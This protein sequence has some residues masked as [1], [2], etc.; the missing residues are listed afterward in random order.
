MAIDKKRVINDVLSLAA[1]SVEDTLARTSGQLPLFHPNADIGETAGEM[2]RVESI[3]QKLGEHINRQLENPDT[4]QKALAETFVLSVVNNLII[5]S[6]YKSAIN[7]YL[8]F[9]ET[10]LDLKGIRNDERDACRQELMDIVDESF[11]I[12]TKSTAA[13]NLVNRLSGFIDELTESQYKDRARSTLN[14]R[15]LGREYEYGF[16]GRLDFLFE[17]LLPIM[18]EAGASANDNDRKILEEYIFDDIPNS[19]R[20]ISELLKQQL[21]VIPTATAE[22]ILNNSN[23]LAAEIDVMEPTIKFIKTTFGSRQN[24][25]E[26]DFEAVRSV[27]N[28]DFSRVMLDGK[29]M[30]DTDT[31]DNTPQNKL[32]AS[33]MKHISKGDS[34]TAINGEEGKITKLTPDFVMAN[35]QKS[36]WRRIVDYFKNL[37]GVNTERK[38]ESMQQQADKDAAEFASHGSYLRESITLDQLTGKSAAKKLETATRQLAQEKENS[39]EI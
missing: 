33:V 38:M 22:A 5:K 16:Q 7:F 3:Y 4:K 20:D 32:E 9:P 35:N 11:E 19:A 8:D 28:N 26:N 17:S 15:E 37:L 23:E 12:K 39:R 31:L 2:P 1:Q 18:V 21:D 30:F 34:V 10:P 13:G 14:Q 29:P 27:I 6:E 25:N 24:E 36:L